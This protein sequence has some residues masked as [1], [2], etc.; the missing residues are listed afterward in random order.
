MVSKV[1]KI[2]IK[3]IRR[4]WVRAIIVFWLKISSKADRGGILL[5]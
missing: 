2:T 4:L 5:W 3:L 1:L